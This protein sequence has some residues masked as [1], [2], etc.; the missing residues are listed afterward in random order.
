MDFTVKSRFDH[1]LGNTGLAARGEHPLN[2]LS[3]CLDLARPEKR[4][5]DV[6]IKRLRG[7]L[8]FQLHR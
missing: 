2:P 7:V 8:P 5:G 6:R 3:P 1:R 4:V